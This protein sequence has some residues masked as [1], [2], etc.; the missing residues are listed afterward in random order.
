ME[1]FS[2]LEGDV[3]QSLAR[4]Q[5]SP[6]LPHKGAVRGFVYDVATGRVDEVRP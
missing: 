5:A 2:D 1:T 3:R 6:F 4:I